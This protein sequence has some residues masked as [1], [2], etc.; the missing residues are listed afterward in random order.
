ML[1]LCNNI[2]T[3]PTFCLG[4]FLVLSD[5]RKTPNTP[6]FPEYKPTPITPRTSK[7]SQNYYNRLAI[8]S[9]L[10]HLRQPV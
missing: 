10:K 6:T 1:F 5:Y 3:F 4:I 7:T 8:F 2:S 9:S